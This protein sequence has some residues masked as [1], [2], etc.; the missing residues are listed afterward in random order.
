MR[1]SLGESLNTV[2]KYNTPLEQGHDTI[3]EALQAFSLGVRHVRGRR[4]GVAFFRSAINWTRI[5]AAAYDAM[6]NENQWIVLHCVENIR[7]AFELR[8]V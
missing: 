8:T 7:K 5:F 6:G 3:L 2:Q 4:C 1:R